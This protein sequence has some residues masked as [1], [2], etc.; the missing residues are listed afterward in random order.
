MITDIISKRNARGLLASKPNGYK[1]KY[2]V[3]YRPVLIIK[4]SSEVLTFGPNELV[5]D[6]TCNPLDAVDL[7]VTGP[8]WVDVGEASIKGNPSGLTVGDVFI[9]QQP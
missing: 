6:L 2:P 7:V 1:I 4:Y 3:I 8:Y 5:P 9:T